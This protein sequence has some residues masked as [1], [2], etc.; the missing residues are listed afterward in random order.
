VAQARVFHLMEAQTVDE[1]LYA[2]V[3]RDGAEIV[4]EVL[5]LPGFQAVATARRRNSVYTLQLIPA[6][7]RYHQE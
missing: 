2:F 5:K 6:S 7:D 3:Q 4:G 1:A